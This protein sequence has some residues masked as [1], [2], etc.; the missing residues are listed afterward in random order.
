[1]SDIMAE[2]VA[3]LVASQISRLKRVSLNNS[4]RRR[5]T[6]FTH[7]PY[8]PRQSRHRYPGSGFQSNLLSINGTGGGVRGGEHGSRRTA[9]AICAI[10]GKDGEGE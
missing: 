4:L 2:S 7:G 1:M 8:A 5:R 10:G 9:G 6:N 3:L